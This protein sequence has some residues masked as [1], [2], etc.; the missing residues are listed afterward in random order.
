MQSAVSFEMLTCK[1][2]LLYADKIR[3]LQDLADSLV[4]RTGVTLGMKRYEQNQILC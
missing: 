3:T 4:V 1:Q 2:P